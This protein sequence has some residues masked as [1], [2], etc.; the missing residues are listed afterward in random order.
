MFTKL[1]FGLLL[2]FNFQL[3]ATDLP[4]GD[5]PSL[6]SPALRPL[7]DPEADIR[8]PQ[9]GAMPS[10]PF[11]KRSNQYAVIISID[12]GGVRGI[13]PTECLRRL[14]Q[15]FE[16]PIAKAAQLIAGASIGGVIAFGFA[17]PQE[18]GEDPLYTGQ[19]LVDFFKTGGPEIFSK[20]YTQTLSTLGGYA[21]GPKY[22]GKGLNNQ[23]EKVFGQ[24]KLSDTL[25]NVMVPAHLNKGPYTHPDHD[26]EAEEESNFIKTQDDFKAPGSFFFKSWQSRNPELGRDFLLKDASRAAAAA[27]TYF[28]AAQ[29]QAYDSEANTHNPFR[30]FDL[31]DGGVYANNPG[32]AA[33]IE[34]QKIYE[35]RNIMM[36][37]FGTGHSKIERGHEE[38][39]AMGAVSM[40]TPVL[41]ANGHITSQTTDY[42]LSQL[43]PRGQFVRID[44]DIPEDCLALDKTDAA[45]FDKLLDHAGKAFSEKEA[46]IDDMVRKIKAGWR[47]SQ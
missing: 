32:M 33:F 38:L 22:N 18:N 11:A 44:P 8:S 5:R 15:K 4:N 42:F 45:H 29:V 16:R 31:Q 12:G 21:R 34:A 19:E 23:L 37:S 3:T 36:F 2:L 7:L 27:H 43:L 26:E 28:P 9:L 13:V 40:V 20:S 17:T 14:E 46:L 6:S 41:D 30:T 39:N 25:T 47:Y 35:P 1:V 10:S 24:T